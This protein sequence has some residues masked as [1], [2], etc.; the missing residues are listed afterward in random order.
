MIGVL[1][2]DEKDLVTLWQPRVVYWGVSLDGFHIKTEKKFEKR[3]DV[4]RH[5]THWV[6]FLLPMLVIQ[7]CHEN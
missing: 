5:H 6:E 3:H 1:S 7:I 4:T 2:F